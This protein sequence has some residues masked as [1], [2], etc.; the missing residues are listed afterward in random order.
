MRTLDTHRRRLALALAALAGFVDA[1]AYMSADRYFV[2]F[3]SGNTTRIGVELA[4]QPHAAIFPALLALAFVAGVIGGA[5]LVAIR[6]KQHKPSLLIF[7]AVLLA[8]GGLLGSLSAPYWCLLILAGAMGALNNSFSR[9]GQVA[10]GLTYMT[11]ALVRMGQGLAALLTGKAGAGWSDWL[12]L[13]FALACGA[14]VGA[15]AQT[16]FSYGA[17]WIASI[18]TTLLAIAARWIPDEQSN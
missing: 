1:A 3:M 13:W 8:L 12:A 2:S 10:I 4:R 11:G 7:V 6:P 16:E 17:F 18:Y 5:L 14:A 15:Y 9:E